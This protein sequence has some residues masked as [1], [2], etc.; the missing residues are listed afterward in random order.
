MQIKCFDVS[1]L[2]FTIRVE[3]LKKKNSV[4]EKTTQL[5]KIHITIFTIW[6]IDPL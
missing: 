1:Y 3:V 5:V 2:L 4:M 6:L